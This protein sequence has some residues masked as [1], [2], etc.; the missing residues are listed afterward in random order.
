MTI[1]PLVC[2]SV[3]V[4][5]LALWNRSL[6]RRLAE[7]TRVATDAGARASTESRRAKEFFNIID[8]LEHERDVWKKLYNDSSYHSG[9]A[10]SWLLRDLSGAIQRS[11][12]FARE[13]RAHGVAAKDVKIDPALTDVLAEFGHRHGEGAH[14][15]VQTAPG[16]EAARK[17]DAELPGADSGT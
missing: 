17:I 6:R 9:V 11:N 13:L 2:L 8:G 5:L 16:I 15:G 4:V 10:Q 14:T 12:A 7:V 1:L 3:L